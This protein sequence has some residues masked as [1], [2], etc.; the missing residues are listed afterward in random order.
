MK[1]PVSSSDRFRSLP[2]PTR[3]LV[4]FCWLQWS[5]AT[6]LLLVFLAA[7]HLG[8]DQGM[9]WNRQ[10]GVIWNIVADGPADRAGLVEGDR[11]AAVDGTPTTSGLPLF[12]NAS[13]WTDTR[14]LVER[15]GRLIRLDLQNISQW[16]SRKT[17]IRTGGVQLLDSAARYLGVAVNFWMLFLAGAILLLRPSLAQARAAAVALSFWIGGNAL[18]EVPGVGDL[19]G[20][21]PVA[22]RFALH[23]VDY[24]FYVGFVALLVHFALLFP[25]PLA[26]VRRHRSV[27]ALP[28]LFALPVLLL[29]LVR[30]ARVVDPVLSNALPNLYLGGLIQLY[31]PI[32]M[33]LAI[34]ILVT[35]LRNEPME[36]ERRRLHWVLSSLLPPFAAWIFLL[37]LDTMQAPVTLIVLG[38]T[39]FWLG[40][41]SGSAIFAWAIVRHRI[42][43]TRILLRK[44]IQYALARGTLLGLIAVP[45][46]VLLA[47]LWVNRHR[48]IAQLISTDLAA[49]VLILAPLAILLQYRSSLLNWID[50]RFFRNDY[51]SQQKL[52]HLISMI[53][54]GSDLTVLSRLAVREIESA[55]HPTHISCWTL[56]PGESVFR[57]LIASGDPV[58]TPALARNNSVVSMMARQNE[59]I[60]IDLLYPHAALKRHSSS[61]QF[62]IWLS[63]TRAALLIPIIVDQEL[64]GFLLLGRRRSEEPYSSRDRELLMTVARQLA[65][66]ESY[67]RLEQIARQ[68]PLTAALNR[69]AYYSLIEKRGDRGDLDAGCVAIVDLDDLKKINDSFG[70][71]AGD[72][73]I[74]QVASA[75]RSVLRAD[76][77]VFR[78]GG[79]EFL[80]ILFGISETL[81]RERLGNINQALEE[82]ALASAMPITVSIGLS[83]FANSGDLASAIDR[84]DAD[85]YAN[86]EYRRKE[87]TRS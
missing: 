62:W 28:Y 60:Q 32:M 33:V 43:E 38:R 5:V 31:S 46:T 10:S 29:A 61:G 77:L 34:T 3:A 84:A 40:V 19:T 71:A 36:T 13:P 17:G 87:H 48:T 6:V 63:V 14:L 8:S 56:D 9:S 37:A 58:S 49:L 26:L 20:D 11:I 65:I 35:H 41:A 79:D 53:Q 4:A 66:A 68:D 86:K 85:M 54:K 74:R 24:L 78:W 7:A 50:R 44:S 18:L 80:V 30:V 25:R 15:D 57:P 27:Q 59:P 12:Y 83:P 39:I 70:H 55:L 45:A 82:N 76:D 2:R 1:E 75:V 73:A 51:D 52:I 67:T 22:L 42:F 47:F 69:H 16:E 23:S 81:G 72:L 21:W 64:A